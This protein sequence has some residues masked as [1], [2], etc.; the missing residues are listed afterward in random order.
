MP[1]SLLPILSV[2]LVSTSA[3]PAPVVTWGWWQYGG[4]SSSV[5]SSL[6]SGVSAIYSTDNTFAALKTDGSVVTWGGSD[7]GGDSSSV[8]SLLASGVSAIYSTG[9]AFAA[10]KTDGSVVTWGDLGRGGDSSSV[11]SFLASGVSAIYSTVGA[12]ATLP[13]S[14]AAQASGDPHLKLGHGGKA[15]FRGTDKGIYNFAS[16]RP[17]TSRST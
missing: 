5:S 4:D 11:S 1:P 6:T 10:L 7:N 15:D 12:F 9:S 16:S 2:L 17:R 8:S 14:P 13:A 3:T